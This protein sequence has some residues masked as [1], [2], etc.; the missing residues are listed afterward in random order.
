[1]ALV[2]TCDLANLTIDVDNKPSCSSW[3]MTEYTDSSNLVAAMDE[4]L[5]FD[6]ETFGIVTGF[7]WV[8]FLT[9]LFAGKVVRVL[10][11]T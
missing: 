9:A 5:G 3:S 6:A 8:A 7:F 2:L 4:Y 11:R 1:M 10:M